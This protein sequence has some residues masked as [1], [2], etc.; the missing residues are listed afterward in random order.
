MIEALILIFILSAIA[1]TRGD[2]SMSWFVISVIVLFVVGAIG[3]SFS[4]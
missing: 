4:S 1:W 3:G 2:N